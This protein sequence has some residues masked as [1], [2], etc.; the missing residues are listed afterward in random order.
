[1][2]EAL[3]V[4]SPGFEERFDART[5][6]DSGRRGERYERALVR[7]LARFCGR[8]TPLG[9][10]AG[11]TVGRFGKDTH[12]EIEG[13]SK[14][15][16][17]TQID[18]EY[19]MDLVDGLIKEPGF[20]RLPLCV[21]SSL[22]TFADRIHYVEGERTAEGHSY[23]PVSI[24]RSL[25]L[26]AILELATP[27][28]T[29]DALVSSLLDCMPA[30]ELEHVERLVLDLINHQVLVPGCSPA[31]TDVDY[32]GTLIEALAKSTDHK[33]I[34][35]RLSSVRDRLRELD[36]DTVRTPEDYRRIV[37][38]LGR[39]P[40][41]PEIGGLFQVDL[42]KPA[43]TATL[44]V[45]VTKKIELGV[46][47][48]HGWFGPG[49]PDPLEDFRSAFRNRYGDNEVRLAEVLDEEVGIGGRVFGSANDPS[50]LMRGLSIAGAEVER[51]GWDIRSDILLQRLGRALEDGAH[52]IEMYEDDLCLL[53]NIE[54]PPPLPGNFSVK[55]SL[56]AS[57][58]ES[59][60]RGDFQFYLHGAMGPPSSILLGRVSKVEAELR[61]GIASH[62]AEE[63]A[64]YSDAVVA[65]IVY[66][67]KGRLANLQSRPIF[68][69]YEIPYLGRSALETDHQIGADDLWV[70]VSDATVVLRSA[71]LG[72]RVIPRMSSA[73][74]FR[75][76]A[77]TVYR[78]LC[79]LQLQQTC[80]WLHWDWG[81][82]GRARFLP[83]VI[84][85]KLVLAPATWNLGRDEIETLT[86]HEGARRFASLTQWREARRVPRF[87]LL[88]DADEKLLFDLDNPMSAEV[89][90]DSV[91]NSAAARIEEQFPDFGD[92]AV[93]GP[94]GRYIHD[95]VVPFTNESPSP[96]VATLPAHA[97]RSPANRSILPG[98]D[99]L[100]VKLYTGRVT[101]DGILYEYLQPFMG[102]LRA[103]RLRSWFF[104]R[105]A[106]PETHL[107]VRISG[108]PDYLR[109]EVSPRLDEQLQK[110]KE[111]SRIWRVVVD[112]YDREE[113]RY[114]GVAGLDLAEQLFQAD[115]IA[116]IKML[117]SCKGGTGAEVRWRLAL[118]GV[119]R[120]L[121]DFGFST[122]RKA[123]LMRQ[124]REVFGKEFGADR[125]P[126]KHELARRYRRE[127]SGIEAVLDPNGQLDSLFTAG[128]AA[129]RERSGSIRS[130]ADELHRASEDGEL[131]CSIETLLPSYIHMHCNRILRWPHRPQEMV[132]Y[133]M[134]GRYYDSRLARRGKRN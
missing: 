88:N 54:S 75:R 71:K 55:G 114:G 1:M 8:P 84:L 121:D 53:E 128:I 78:F 106:D 23:F 38:G 21:N 66:G 65:E 107:R 134:L 63:D 115:S 117:K 79:S 37:R 72:K 28:T 73:H 51:P 39:L 87:V 43:A 122:E 2:R 17:H 129:L 76:D 127:R 16:K 44:G 120:L 116:V 130:V 61:E 85:D 33:E 13:R 36:A 56:S 119:D 112:T 52:E 81:S 97:P 57:S 11:T 9:I 45:A 111:E 47:W 118:R 100:Y 31:L 89:F 90:A 68:S 49:S 103:A 96:P 26:K 123:G 133:D 15:R 64:R 131:T 77:N 82:L 62:L 126:L 92:L 67:P 7:Y 124:T 113:E 22:F 109:R 105:Y 94:E 102:Q 50:P 10:S 25:L 93:T 91:K 98:S 74:N 41:Y 18:I 46:R 40:V 4:S 34:T 58:D 3:F 101:M 20:G 6:R 5:G 70:S 132:L 42:V 29:R 12:L 27:V 110:L 104:V 30:V 108:D 125:P 32:L 83:R 69:E 24:E 95:L 35:D 48:L 19:L 80:W 60:A 99:W 59:L 14:F 86:K